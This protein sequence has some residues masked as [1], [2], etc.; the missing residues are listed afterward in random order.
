MPNDVQRV[1]ELAFVSTS[2]SAC[3]LEKHLFGSKRSLI[4]HKNIVN[5]LLSIFDNHIF[6]VKWPICQFQKIEWLGLI[7]F[8][9]EFFHFV[10]INQFF[11]L[12][13]TRKILTTSVRQ[14]VNFYV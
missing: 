2:F 5:I 9:Q 11:T 10:S 12:F 13:L 8:T 6:V 7:F 4:E 14:K 1:V 3:Y